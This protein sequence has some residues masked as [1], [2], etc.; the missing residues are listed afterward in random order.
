MHV[1]GKS[2]CLVAK[3]GQPAIQESHEAGSMRAIMMRC[4]ANFEAHTEYISDTGH[5][6]VSP[7][8]PLLR[9]EE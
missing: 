6:A 5:Q 9:T 2:R 7:L 4:S 1:R 3:C 8:T